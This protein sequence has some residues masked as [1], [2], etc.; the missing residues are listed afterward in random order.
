M[1]DVNDL[2]TLEEVKAFLKYDD[3]NAFDIMLEGIRLASI[4]RV[5]SHIDG[6]DLTALKPEQL[7]AIK[8][9][10]FLLCAYID[11][12]RINNAANADRR[13]LPYEVDV[14]LMPFR[15]IPCA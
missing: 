10:V 13:W 1:A 15:S 5:L 7:G 12:G 11:N 4:G 8:N 14:M 6:T 9:A 2:V 3:A